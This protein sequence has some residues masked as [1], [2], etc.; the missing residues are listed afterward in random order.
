MAGLYQLIST[1]HYT[2][3]VLP[4]Q[5]TG[6]DGM[7]RGCTKI[8][9]L[10]SRTLD[11]SPQ[12]LDFSPQTLDF[13]HL[14]RGQGVRRKMAELILKN[15][16]WPKKT[17]IHHSLL[18]SCIFSTRLLNHPPPSFPN[19]PIVSILIR[20]PISF[21]NVFQCS[22]YSILPDFLRKKVEEGREIVAKA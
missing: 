5:H 19:F 16:H 10:L 21:S 18:N 8:K 12:T 3:W 20:L 7:D 9:I 22:I 17:P 15:L 11:I 4:W 6:W 2:S 1:F 13:S 14:T